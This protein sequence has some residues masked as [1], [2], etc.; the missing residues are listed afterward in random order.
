MVTD[1]RFIMDKQDKIKAKIYIAQYLIIAFF[2][3]P[4]AALLVSYKTF[5]RQSSKA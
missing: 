4:Q 5:A 1:Y 2:T 3:S